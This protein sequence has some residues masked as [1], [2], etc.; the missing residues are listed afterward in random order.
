M[1]AK[2]KLS[3]EE[4]KER[5]LES[6]YQIIEEKGGVAKTAELYEAG[7]DYRRLQKFVEEG[8]LERIKSGYYAVAFKEQSQEDMIPVLFPDGVLCMD[9]ALYYHGYL[10]EKPY[11]TL[12]TTHFETVTETEGVINMQ[13]RGLAD[14][15]FSKLNR[16]IQYANRRERINIISKYMD[17]RLYRVQRQGQVPKDA[18]TIAKMLGISKE[19]IDGAQKYLK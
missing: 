13:V 3:R 15:D 7:V 5:Q 12:I 10:K 2:E 19:I 6:I 16:E 18:L 4:K 9:T 14:A 8:K 17:Y 1:E 11:I